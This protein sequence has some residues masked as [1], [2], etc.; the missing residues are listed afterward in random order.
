MIIVGHRGA[1]NLWPENSLTGFRKLARLG[2]KGA[3]VEAVE[4]DVH[5]TR[6]N[7]LVVIH[8]PTLERTTL[9]T[10]RVVERSLAE[11][12]A[13]KLR[14]SDDTIPSLDAVLDV[15]VPAKLELH[16]ELKTGPDNV[17]YE[18][19]EAAVMAVVERRAIQ[20]QSIL[21]CF[22]P[23]V[24]DRL[25]VRWPQIRL[26]ASLNK[27]WADKFGGIDAA[28]DRFAAIPNCLLAVEKTLLAEQYDKCFARIG[29]DRLGV[30]VPNEP[31]DIAFWIDKPIRQMTTDRP[32]LALAAR[33]KIG[34]H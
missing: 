25:R 6:D 3:G 9:G 2:D 17:P 15:L 12:Q 13:T 23:E 31:A 21:T 5:P 8:D 7:K 32:D 28:L 10:G 27:A 29:G 18:G 33:Q 4:F 26:L 14:D 1:R 16:I 34:V 11:L 24:L 30:W 22:A 19:L 20:A